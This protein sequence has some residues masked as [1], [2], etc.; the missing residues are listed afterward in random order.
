MAAPFRELEGLSGTSVAGA[1]CPSAF[2][3]GTSCLSWTFPALVS[4][5]VHCGLGDSSLLAVFLF[6][7]L[8][9]VFE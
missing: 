5:S 9:V 7:I 4:P 6:L 8:L 3:F 2:S 1:L